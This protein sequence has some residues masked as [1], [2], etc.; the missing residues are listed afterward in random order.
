MTRID[1]RAGALLLA[2]LTAQATL[3]GEEARSIPLEYTSHGGV[4]RGQLKVTKDTV[5]V[6]LDHG[7]E[8]TFMVINPNTGL[9]IHKHRNQGELSANDVISFVAGRVLSN[10]TGKTLRKLPGNS[11][12]AWMGDRY[13]VVLDSNTSAAKVEAY[14]GEETKPVWSMSLPEVSN[15]GWK[16]TWEISPVVDGYV[17]TLQA[18]VQGHKYDSVFR[19]RKVNLKGKTLYERDFTKQASSAKQPLYAVHFQGKSKSRTALV[20]P[21][22]WDKKGRGGLSLRFM[23]GKKTIFV[24]GGTA[25]CW[26]GWETELKR[27]KK[28]LAF[29][30]LGGESTPLAKL[31]GVDLRKNRI[32]SKV[33]IPGPLSAVSFAGY[34]V[35]G[36]EL[37]DM[38]EGKQIATLDPPD[39]E[40]KGGVAFS[41]S[42]LV[43]WTSEKGIVLFPLA[44]GDPIRPELKLEAD[45]IRLVPVTPRCKLVVLIVESE[46]TSKLMTLDTS[47]NAL[48]TLQTYETDLSIQE[49]TYHE[50]R[51]YLLT[52]AKEGPHFYSK[53]ELWIVPAE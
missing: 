11:R 19:V 47:T 22:A 37:W 24:P 17:M 8:S 29:V 31:Q 2:L 3:A 35:N 39:P 9:P 44:G 26:H 25:F 14:R 48:R 30:G 52:A 45:T 1:V 46:G 53:A 20:I 12:Y 42:H 15:A 21:G 16:P 43:Q 4:V 51:L 6:N 7:S 49:A 50:G 27:G 33:V 40:Q 28:R 32:A 10:T 23:K 38:L 36:R 13:L 34:G 5:V 41:E 18:R